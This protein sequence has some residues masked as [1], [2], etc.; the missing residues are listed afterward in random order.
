MGRFRF[1][2]ASLL[3]IV[4]FVAIAIAAL[5]ASN[6]A[7]DSSVLGLTLLTLLAAAL[8]AVHRTDR[9]RAFWLG[10]AVFGWIYLFASLIPQIALRLPTTLG[11]AFIDSKIPGRDTTIPPGFTYPITYNPVQAGG[12]TPQFY[13]LPTSIQGNVWIWDTTTDKLVPGPGSTT[14]N[15]LRIGHS[16]LALVLAIV[17]GQLSR[18]LYR[19]GERQAPG[20]RHVSTSPT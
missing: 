9:R 15:F 18:Y 7:W 4:L 5:R 19:T 16:F 14:E 11:L 1:S 12:Y 10:F 8:L 13:T 17:G 2:I 20:A 6:D 3:G